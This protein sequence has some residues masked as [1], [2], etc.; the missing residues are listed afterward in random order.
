VFLC[1]L[2]FSE[3]RQKQGRF[4]SG[5]EERREEK[6]WGEEGGKTVVRM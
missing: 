4:G 5:E 2:L 6:L 3:G 1:G